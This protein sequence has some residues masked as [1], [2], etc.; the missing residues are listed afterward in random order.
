MTPTSKW[1]THSYLTTSRSACYR[2][3][4][5]YKDGWA[6]CLT[7]FMSGRPNHPYTCNS[8]GNILSW[9]IT[10]RS[11]D[12]DTKCT[13]S[14]E[15]NMWTWSRN[16]SWAVKKWCLSAQ[17]FLTLKIH[18]YFPFT[19]FIQFTTSWC[20]CVSLPTGYKDSGPVTMTWCRK[21][22]LTLSCTW[23]QLGKAW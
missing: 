12:L 17:H 8:I 18:F 3:N 15:V 7:C 21:G 2:S 22:P 10:F 13:T 23:Y 20:Q 6:P 11:R 16:V 4:Y 1:V 9:S 5:K 14:N 19:Y